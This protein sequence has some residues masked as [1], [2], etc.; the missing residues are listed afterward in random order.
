MLIHCPNARHGLPPSPLVQYTTLPAVPALGR[1]AT[2][3]LFSTTVVSVTLGTVTVGS[4]NSFR[5]AELKSTPVAKVNPRVTVTGN[6]HYANLPTFLHL[7]PLLLLPSLTCLKLGLP[8]VTL[9][10]IFAPYPRVRPVPKRKSASSVPSAGMDL[11][12]CL[13][14]V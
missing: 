5:F 10:S 9:I 12:L 13:H 1:S 3:K 2:A 11:L 6:C 4:P 8:A 14:R 7:L